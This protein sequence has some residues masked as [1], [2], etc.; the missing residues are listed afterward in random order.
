[1]KS[2]F[3]SALASLLCTSVI[4]TVALI[5]APSA[6]AATPL[7]LSLQEALSRAKATGPEVTRARYALREADAKRVGAGLVVPGNPRLQVEARPL[8]SGGSGR[9]GYSASLDL[10]FD[11]GGA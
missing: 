4:A 1:M 11:L 10:P 7:S 3:K 9:M 2:R 5:A 6:Q 8:V